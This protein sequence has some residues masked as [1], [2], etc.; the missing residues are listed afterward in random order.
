MNEYKFDRYFEISVESINEIYAIIEAY[1]T[2]WNV[3]RSG[4]NTEMRT[5]YRGQANAQWRIEPSILRCE[6][7]EGALY[8]EYQ[9]K[10]SGKNLFDQFAYLQHYGTG[11]RLID[12]TMNPDVALYFACSKETM[13]DSALYLYIY[14]AHCAEWIDT[15]I[16][17]EIMQI[18]GFNTL[19]ISEFSNRLFQKYPELHKRFSRASELD[20]FLMGYLDHGYMVYPGNGSE[21][22]NLRIKRQEGVFFICG[23]QFTENITDRMRVE[24]QA[25]KNEFICHSVSIPDS[26]KEGSHCLVKIIINKSLKTKILEQLKGK[27]ITYEYLFPDMECSLDLC[28]NGVV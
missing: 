2:Y 6:I 16:F 9:S 15:I 7:D 17:T 28:G 11:T 25:G 14:D 21:A 23:V 26:L 1:N 18:K 19:K 3:P 24:S 10:L 12:F 13:S 20:L 22:T 4:G 8:R 27:E 5:F